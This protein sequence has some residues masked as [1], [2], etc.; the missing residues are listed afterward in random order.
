MPTHPATEP[1]LKAAEHTGLQPTITSS[2][3]SVTSLAITPRA[4]ITHC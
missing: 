4:L 3:R 2:Q 1:H